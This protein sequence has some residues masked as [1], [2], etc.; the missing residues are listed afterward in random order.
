MNLPFFIQ[1]A[2][3]A[4]AA[5]VAFLLGH[6][7][8]AATLTGVVF[9]LGSLRAF[10]PSV[11]NTVNAFVQFLGKLVS[12]A[13][14][15]VLLSAIYYTIFLFGRLLLLVRGTDPLNRRFPSNSPTNWNDR[16]NYDGDRTI[17]RKMYSRPHAASGSGSHKK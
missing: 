6:P 16:T 15:I 3:P 10:A 8:I 13:I 5:A 14:G 12:T 1:V 9:L 2:V 7:Y 11:L 17:Y 4:I